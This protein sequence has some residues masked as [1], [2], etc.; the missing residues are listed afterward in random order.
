MQVWYVLG[1]TE[2][3]SFPTLFKFKIDAEALARRLFPNETPARRYA[4][5]MCR[6][7]E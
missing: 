6:T 3:G 1:E 2:D 4:R 5:I 7:V